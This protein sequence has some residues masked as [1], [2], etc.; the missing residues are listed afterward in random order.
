M[1]NKKK[2]IHITV[3]AATFVLVSLGFFLTGENLVSLVNMD[4]KITFSSSVIIMLFFSPLI[5][6]CMVSIILSNITNR[7]PKYHDSFIK[8]FGS[9][10]I[11]SLFLSFPTSLYVNYKL[12]SENYLICQKISLTSPNTYVKDMKLCD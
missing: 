8:Y 5:W 1:E 9:I 7:C 6:Y 2:I 4:E 3:A 12:R 10:A 11:I